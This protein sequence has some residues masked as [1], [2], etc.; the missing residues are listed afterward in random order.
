MNL[1]NVTGNL[2]QRSILMTT[3]EA[4]QL[5]HGVFFSL[6]DITVNLRA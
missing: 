1:E 2:E 5:H 3:Y 6:R 4:I